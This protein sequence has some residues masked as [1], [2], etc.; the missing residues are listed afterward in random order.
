MSG[1]PQE[2]KLLYVESERVWKMIQKMKESMWYAMIAFIPKG[3]ADTI[4]FIVLVF[5][6]MMMLIV[7]CSKQDLCCSF[8]S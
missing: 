2:A 1:I 6:W 4:E 3:N 5:G 8:K 7:E